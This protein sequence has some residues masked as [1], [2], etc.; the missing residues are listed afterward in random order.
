MGG[1]WNDSRLVP[2]SDWISTS[3]SETWVHSMSKYCSYSHAVRGRGGGRESEFRREEEGG[4]EGEREK[5]RNR[6]SVGGKGG[7]EG[8]ER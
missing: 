1:V 6:V 7:R 5:R 2:T 4:R 3:C 8:K